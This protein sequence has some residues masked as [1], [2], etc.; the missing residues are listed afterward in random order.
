VE[1]SNDAGGSGLVGS[2]D[3]GE[4]LADGLLISVGEV[5]EAA[6]AHRL[7][8][9]R[10]DALKLGAAL[11]REEN[12]ET[13]TVGGGETAIEQAVTFH[14]IEQMGEA[15]TT[16]HR[17]II[18]DLRVAEQDLKDVGVEWT[19]LQPTFFMQNTMM[20][21]QS[22]QEMG[23]VFFD[24]ADDKAGMIGALTTDGDEFVGKEVSYVSVP[25]EKAKESMVGMGLLESI[26]DGF[27]ELAEGFEA[28]FADLT[29]DSVQQ[30]AGYAPRSFD[31]FA[32][33]FRSAWGG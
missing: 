22:V 3:L 11:G 33:D 2:D 12:V 27:V 6:I 19:I 18:K 13:A 8:M 23:M 26:V 24:W 17:E 29:T 10:P 4:G 30:L 28:G 20:A 25:H 15:A 1:G 32:S 9:A 14:A 31:E 16:E 21:A 5:L 7:L